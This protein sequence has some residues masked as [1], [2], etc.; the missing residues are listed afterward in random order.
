MPVINIKMIE[1]RTVDQKRKLVDRVTAAICET[2]HCCKNAVT[3]VIEDIP[4]ENWG[5]AGILKI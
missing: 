2:C 5:T 4:K 1:G 3:V